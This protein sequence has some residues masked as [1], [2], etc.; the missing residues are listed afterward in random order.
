MRVA[1]PSPDEACS[2][3]T[4]DLDMDAR[5]V[6]RVAIRALDGAMCLMIH[7]VHFY[8]WALV[9][10]PRLMIKYIVVRYLDIRARVPLEECINVYEEV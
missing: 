8:I 4:I 9:C 6:P 1:V 3:F 5:Y 7:C 10:S 2:S